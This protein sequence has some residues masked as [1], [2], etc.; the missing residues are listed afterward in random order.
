MR[1]RLPTHIRVPLCAVVSASVVWVACLAAGSL[2][3]GAQEKQPEKGAKESGEKTELAEFLDDAKRYTIKSAKSDTALKLREQPILN[4]TNPERN[5]ELGSVV[6]WLDA[7][8]RPAV[9]G[10]FF[11][12]DAKKGRVKKHA[13]HSLAAVE[14][15]AKVGDK[16]AWAPEAP[17]VEWK[18]F[19]DAPAVAVNQK[20]RLRQMKLL[21]Q[22]VQVSLI[23]PRD[24]EKPIELRRLDQPL[25][26]YA[27]PKAGVTT[28]A[29]FS[30]VV[31]TDPEAILL[32]E[33][34]DEKGKTGFRYAF[35]RF[36][37]WGLNAK[38][39]DKA[40]W[41]VEFDESQ[42]NNTIGRAD[43]VKKVYNSFLP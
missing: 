21:A 36:H 34:F 8:D 11:K 1:Y 14:L 35:A 4:F 43:T 7:D 22:R 19:P 17:G 31:A 6:V 20:D 42:V 26:E 40:V 28:G 38:I 30:Y 29:I 10:Q 37:F 16:L 18:S 13:L 23:N 32:I 3:A 25:F 27:A 9:M 5:Q 24:K 15:E 12:Y 39:D 41:T 33:S 2:P